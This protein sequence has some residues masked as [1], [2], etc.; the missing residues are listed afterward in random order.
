MSYS[1]S[2]SIEIGRTAGDPEWDNVRQRDKRERGRPSG[3]RRRPKTSNWRETPMVLVGVARLRAFTSRS[4]IVLD[5]R[6]DFIGRT[7]RYLCRLYHRLSLGILVTRKQPGDII[8]PCVLE[9][10]FASPRNEDLRARKSNARNANPSI[11]SGI[12]ADNSDFE[13][14]RRI[15]DNS[16]F[17][18][19]HVS[20]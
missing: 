17:V 9:K 16:G 10:A 4:A 11:R 14:L 15:I 12:T 13:C 2:D 1:A 20:K 5:L 8:R 7:P 19:F 3:F 6:R 18:T